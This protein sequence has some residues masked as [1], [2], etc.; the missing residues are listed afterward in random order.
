MRA[1]ILFLISF[2]IPYLSFGQSPDT[3]TNDSGGWISGVVSSDPGSGALP[4]AEVQVENLGTGEVVFTGVDGRF[5]FR[6]T[7]TSIWLRFSYPGFTTKERLILDPGDY[8]LVMFGQDTRSIDLVQSGPFGNTIAYQNSSHSEITEKELNLASDPNFENALQGKIPGL[9]VKRT[10]GMPGDGALLNIRGLNSIF[11]SDQAL[12]VL[13]GVPIRSSLVE[14]RIISGGMYNPLS[15]IDI[16][17]IEKIEVI[18]DGSSLYGVQGNQGIIRVTTKQP[19]TV[20]TRIE[21]SA[22]TGMSFEPSFQPVLSGLEYKTYLLNLLQGSGLSSGEIQQQNPWMSGNPSYFYYYNYANDTH[23]QDEIMNISNTGKYNI[24]LQGGDEIARFAVSLGYL[25]QESIV[26]NTGLQ[27]YNFR[28]NAKLQVLQQLSLETNIAYSY[29]VAQLMNTGVDHRLNPIAAAL[30]KAPMLAPYQRDNLGNRISLLT[31]ADSYGFS[32]PVAI[33]DKTESGRNGS[34]LFASTRASYHLTEGLD[35]SALIHINY[36]SLKENVFIP[37]YGI[38]DFS[39]GEFLNFAREGISKISG[40]V[41]EVRVD[42]DN[43]FSRKHFIQAYGGFRAIRSGFTYHEGDVFNTPTDEFKSLSSVSSIENTLVTGSNREENRSE[44]FV[45]ADYRLLDRFL[46]GLTLNLSGTSN[47]GKEADAI[48]FAGGKWGFFPGF[49]FGWLV[50]SERFLRRSS[51]IDLLK[52]RLNLNWAG[53]DFFSSQSRFAYSSTPYGSHS[54]IYRNYLPNPKLKWE[55]I[56]Q[57]GIGLDAAFYNERIWFSIDLFQRNTTDLLMTVPLPAISGYDYY[58]DNNGELLSKGAE[59]NLVVKPLLNRNWKIILG[60]NAGWQNSKVLIPQ[61]LVIDIPGGQWILANDERPFCFYGLQTNGVFS[62]RAEALESGLKN[63]RGVAFQGGDIRFIDQN[64]DQIIDQHDRTNLGSML[65]N[66]TGGFQLDVSWKS[67][68]IGTWLDFSYGNKIFNY[69]RMLSES[70]SGYGNQ[71][72][73]SLYSWKT[74]GVE[75]TVPRIS[76]EDPAGNAVFSDRWIED[77]SYIS[78]RDITISY[79]LPGNRVYKNLTLFVT[80]RDLWTYSPYLGYSPE[81]G[82]SMDPVY[83]GIDY[84]QVPLSTSVVAGVKFEL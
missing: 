27:R 60:A 77:G 69:Q 10:S 70:L 36:T 20:N 35:V 58:W 9:L 59:L 24:S 83:W 45:Q 62:S 21:F 46:A 81:F 84:M 50:S 44:F 32:N 15:A 64:N 14:S 38:A 67:L 4:L 55:T 34:D 61:D 53:N 6:W 48:H 1:L 72:I 22:L 68:S 25:D 31:D 52:L 49:H 57:G 2:W 63:E 66:L 80:A 11:A 28:L 73:A 76:Y 79:K 56:R 17:D 37:D 16:N 43:E 13:D 23:W 75:A 78:L 12:V 7:D 18:R 82:F 5:R 3:L 65:P 47:A 54:G 8:P 39:E 42:Y 19:E 51:F 33:V 74:E 41:S 30:F 26:K 71:S 40:L 29:H